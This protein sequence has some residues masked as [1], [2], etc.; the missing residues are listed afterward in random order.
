MYFVF[1]FIA[2]IVLLGFLLLKFLEIVFDRRGY[3]NKAN[4]IYAALLFMVMVATFINIIIAVYS[5]R[6]TITMAGNVGD[7]GIRGNR[8]S[9][10]AK[11]ICNEKCGQKVC[12]VE[13][14]DHA[15]DVFKREV[16]TFMTENSINTKL[17][18]K[19][20]TIK[21]GFFLDKINSIC[22][23]E[24]Y[25]TIMLGKHP[26]KP[27]EKKLIEYIKG[28]IEEWIVYLVS[29]KLN[30]GCLTGEDFAIDTDS[31]GSYKCTPKS[32]INHEDNLIEDRH[33]GVRFLLDKQYTTDVLNFR[34]SEKTHN[35][36][37]EF[38]KYD[39]WNWGDGLKI[40]PL[41]IKIKTKNL[42]LPEP[43]EAR[44]QITK[45]NN[46]GW[47]FDTNTQKD[48][49]DDTNCEYNQM[50]ED[51]T[52][53]Q[54]LSKC[55]YV[56]KT[57]YL[58]DY[59]NTW[60]TDVY[61]KGPE[62]SLYNADSYKDNETNQQFYPVGSVWRG[63]EN[64]KKPDGTIRTPGSK[65]SCGAG[66]GADGSSKANN[67]GPEKETILV[68]GDVKP[69]EKLEFIWDNKTG[70]SD[71]HNETVKIY[72][73]KAPEGYV[74][75]GD[76]AKSGDLDENDLEKIRCVPKE[77]IREK[78][79]GNKFY[80]NKTVSFD[81]YQDY[82]SY[83]SRT[84]FESDRQLSASLWAAGIDNVGAAEE[85]HNNYGLEYSEDGGYNLF[86]AGRGLRPPKLKTYTIK[87]ECLLPG[88]GAEPV[89]PEFDAT[90]FLRSTDSNNRYNTKEY[91]GSKPPFAILTND[92]KDL[93][94]MQSLKNFK[95]KTLRLYLEDDLTT[96]KNTRSDTYFIKTFNPKKNDFSLY[97]IAR[98]DGSIELTT[99]V[100]KKNKFHRWEIKTENQPGQNFTFSV[101]IISYGL[102]LEE[103]GELSLRQ[104]YDT[105]SKSQFELVN[106]STP[107]WIY[108]SMLELEAPQYIKD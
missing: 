44:I 86:R 58:K 18:E 31:P 22:K 40:N 59:V 96:R 21:N 43:D 51:K 11:G 82:K 8:G 16:E 49:W 54:N 13:I 39:V 97:I 89:H 62:L 60:K 100:S 87:E 25:Q 90:E 74:C 52:N 20:Y 102:K 63:T 53:P 67:E 12:Y 105:M 66:H 101:N 38:K 48:K 85:Q 33:R 68:S 1:Y 2:G 5:Y 76:F 15:N 107:N 81:K 30:I 83:V 28:I 32:G 94:N 88:G 79:L 29:D 45:S 56:N 108:N 92:D 61:N 47:V 75:L 7:R 24:Q 106:I 98:I 93:G 14:I 73:P 46:Y 69:P 72:R 50:G 23:S 27:S 34:D 41:E 70:C 65:N 55:V 64:K 6:K 80:D 84:P 104:Y 19:E 103:Q 37:N 99:S 10:G 78:R 17:K 71:C 4:R 57:N 95:K 91:F 3:A 36:I 26:D 35:P 42:E 77:C 9:K